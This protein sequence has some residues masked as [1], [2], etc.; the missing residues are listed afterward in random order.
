MEVVESFR[1]KFPTLIEQ[2]CRKYRFGHRKIRALLCRK[3]NKQVNRKTVQRIMQ[4][5]NLQCRTK[6][7]R[8]T[9]INGESRI[10]VAN[11]RNRDFTASK[12]NEKWVTD[13]TYRQLW[14]CITTKSSLTE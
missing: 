3:H 11:E 9:Y 14:T 7:K 4:K 2:L 1:G 10:V 13:I 12:P 6:P 8:K 5:K